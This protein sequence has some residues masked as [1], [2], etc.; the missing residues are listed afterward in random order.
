M[1]IVNEI[2]NSTRDDQKVLG[3]LYIGLPGNEILTITFQYNLPLSYLCPLK[4]E[5]LFLVPHLLPLLRLHCFHLHCVPR[6]WDFS[7]GNR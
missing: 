6:G 1:L 2:F 7:F 5:G 4:I 3:L